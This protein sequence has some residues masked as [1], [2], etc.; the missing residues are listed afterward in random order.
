MKISL[1]LLAA[2]N[3]KRFTRNKLL[4]VVDGLPMYLHIVEKT[5]RSDVFFERIIVT[6]Y[7]EIMNSEH[8]EGFK[9]IKNCNSDL[10]ISSSIKLGLTACSEQSE[11]FCFIVCDQPYLRQETIENFVLQFE[12]SRK[13]LGCVTCESH[14]GNPAIFTS[15]YKNELLSFTGD[16][17]GMRIIKGTSKDKV[18]FYEVADRRELHDIDR[19]SDVL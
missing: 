9:V 15:Q 1:I 5:S 6:Q 12:K 13:T 2:G 10:G 18:F 7:E 11:A 16:M 17:G 8:L 19:L 4:E 14:Y 3:S